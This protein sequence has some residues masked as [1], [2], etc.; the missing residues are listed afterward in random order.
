[1]DG[2]TLNGISIEVVH[3]IFDQTKELLVNEYALMEL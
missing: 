1:M 3:F 2:K